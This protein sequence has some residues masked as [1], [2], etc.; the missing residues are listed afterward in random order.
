VSAHRLW[1][2]AQA[3]QS[4]HFERGIPRYVTALVHALHAQGVDLAGVGL[5]PSQALPA[6]PHRS[7]LALPTTT[8]TTAEHFRSALDAGPLTYV[9]ASPFEGFRPVQNLWPP[10]VLDSGMPIATVVYDTIPF[11]DPEYGSREERAFHETRAALVRRS[12][13][14][15]AIS[16]STG[17]D[18]AEDLGIDPSRIAVI[19][20]GVA[21]AFRPDAE[22]ATSRRLLT[23]ALPALRH[24]FVFSVC[25]WMER[26]NT[27]GL[28]KAWGRVPPQVRRA[29]QLVITCSLRADVLTRWEALIDE[30][31]LRDDVLLTGAVDDDVLL[32]LYRSAELFVYPS[33]YEGFGLPIAESIE[34]GTPAISSNTSSMPEVVG[35][36]PGLFDPDDHDGIAGLVVQALTDSAFRADLATACDAARGRHTWDAVAA[37]L[38]DAVDR[39]ERTGPGAGA[40]RLRRYAV[41]AAE[42]DDV[43]AVIDGLAEH[44]HVDCFVS[45]PRPTAT[46]ARVRVLPVAAFGRTFEPAAY[47]ERVYSLDATAAHV[48]VLQHALRHPG[49]VCLAT[50][51]LGPLYAAQA[52]VAEEPGPAMARLLDDLYGD[53]VPERTRRGEVLDG[54]LLTYLGAPCTAALVRSAR[55]VVVGSDEDAAVVRLDAGPLDAVPPILVGPVASVLAERLGP[56]R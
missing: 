41:V 25:G 6:A 19:G 54:N 12:D 52:G 44:A 28:I 34:C 40:A 42:G 7:L 30:L 26:K 16:E 55:A 32:A 37:R 39:L 17:R 51:A 2:D 10:F 18:T 45:G 35:W 24:P 20:S 9:Q 31:G 49:V 27:D 8:W 47:D 13:V 43:L 36:E 56:S 48:P 11:R 46:H 29:H 5:N 3:V 50:P 23:G 14:V 53:R 38:L 33:R 15:L 21:N 1:I 22:P 4:P